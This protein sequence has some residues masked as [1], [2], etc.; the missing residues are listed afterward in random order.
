M[1]SEGYDAAKLEEA[2]RTVRADLRIQQLGRQYGI[3]SENRSVEDLIQKIKA[4]ELPMNSLDVGAAIL[5]T[6]DNM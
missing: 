5:E 4:G 1:G 6:R 3:Q 2:Q